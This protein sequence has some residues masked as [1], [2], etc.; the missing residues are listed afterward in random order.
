MPK[1][2]A[3]EWG[4]DVDLLFY[5]RK[6]NAKIKSIPTMWD[7]KK[8][9]KINLKKT[10]L[11]MFLSVIRLRLIHSPFNFVVRFYRKLPEKWKFH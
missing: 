3:N 8:G 1:L 4:F 2:G 9:S 6:E 10:P 7:D 5:S 11:T